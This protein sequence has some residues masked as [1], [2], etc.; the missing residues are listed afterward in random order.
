MIRFFFLVVYNI[1]MFVVNK[2]RYGSRWSS[3]WLQRI[4]PSANVKIFGNGCISIGRNNEISADCDIQVHGKGRFSIGDGSYMNRFC[5]ISA[6]N[7]VSIGNHCMFGPCVKIFDN[8]HRFSREEG[9]SSDLT[10]GSVRIG[11]NCWI[12]SNVIILK[13]AEIGDNCVI[14][15]GCLIS[16]VVPSGSIVKMKQEQIIQEIK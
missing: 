5:M 2:F 13:G 4:S 7:S 10:V 16:G 14:G 9:V 11:D 12:A 1:F 6:H 8:N 15:A 3:H